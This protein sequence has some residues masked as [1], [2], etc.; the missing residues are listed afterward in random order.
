MLDQL[1]N[2]LLIILH[3]F[4][5][6]NCLWF[7]SLCLSDLEIWLQNKL[8]CIPYISLFWNSL[9][10]IGIIFLWN[11]WLNLPNEPVWNWC[12]LSWKVTKY[13]FNF[14]GRLR[15][16]HITYFLIWN[17]FVKLCLLQ[18]QSILIRLW[19]LWT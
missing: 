10:R 13:W 6:D 7:S 19:D 8:R 14:F 17:S 12:F 9:W 5:K 4:L 2:N 1:I 16:V 18:N 15:L 3:L 11:V